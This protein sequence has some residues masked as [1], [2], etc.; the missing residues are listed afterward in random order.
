[1][2]LARM[3]VL[4]FLCAMAAV[5]VGFMGWNTPLFLWLHDL[6]LGLAQAPWVYLTLIGDSSFTPLPLVYF[7]RRRPDLPWAALLAAW[8]AQAITHTL[9]P[10]IDEPR[11]PAVLDITVLGP[12]LM[13]GGFPSGHTTSIFLLAGL[14]TLG[15]PLRAFPGMF[16]WIGLAALVGFSRI[17]VGVHWPVDVLAGAAIGWACAAAGLALGKRWP[18]GSRGRGRWL[19]VIVLAITGIYDLSGDHAGFSGVTWFRIGAPLVALA[20][21][22]IDWWRTHDPRARA[23]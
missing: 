20:W 16:L 22:M 13:H 17:A 6:L 23:H 5:T 10:L 19:P 11:P 12:H 9:K 15:I 4:P 7:L 8:L 1:M 2:T 21:G 14:M 18:W 3:L